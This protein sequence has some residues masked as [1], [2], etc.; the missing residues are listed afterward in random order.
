MNNLFQEARYGFRMLAKNPGFTLVVVLTLALGI[1]ANSALF[2]VV[3][4]VLLKPLPFADAERLV[5][6]WNVNTKESGNGFSVSY[7]DFNDY[8]V[9][10]QSFEQMAAFRTRDLTLTGMGEA[11]RLRGATVTSDLFPLLGVAPQLGRVFTPE[12]DKA[13]NHAAILSDTLWRTRFKADP[14]AV[15]RTVSINSQSYTIV[16][17][18]PPK[19]TFPISSDPAELWIGAAVDNEGGGG[20]LTNQRGNHTIEVIGRLKPGATLAQAQAEMSR[21][22]QALE[23]QYPGENPDT[24]A[25]VV[26]FFERVVGDVKLA[27]LLLLGAVGCVLLIACGNVANLLLA[28]AASRQKE[29]AV[30]AALGANRW[31]VVR[32]LLVESLLLALLGGGAGLLVAWWG[33]DLLLKLVPGGL[34]RVGETTLNA[35]VLGFTLLISVVTGVL[36]GLVP[37][38]HSSRF[39]LVTTLKEGGRG[40]G[41]G[42]RGNRTRNALIVAQVAIAFVLLVCAGLL[43]NSFW[44]LQQVNPGFDP[45]N[46]L[47]F[48]VSLP[49]TKYAQNEQ[50]ESFYQRLTSRVG[51]LPGV[52]SVSATS[53]LP[54]SGQ[55]SGVGFAIEGVP[56][57]PN[58]PFPHESSLRI[59]QPGYFSTMK[60][61]L[62]Q[63]RDFDAR[64]TLMGSQVVIINETLARK[65]FLG[66]NPIGRRINPS[67]GID[68]RG[69]QWREIVGIVKDVHHASLKEAADEESYVPHAQAPVNSITMV[70]RTNNDPHNLI[71]SVGREVSALDGELPIFNVR[72]LEETLSRSLAQQRFNTL[73]L[74]IFA[75]VALLLTAV[76]LYGVLA[77]SVT[78][79]T[80]EFG[81]R[82][83]LGAQAR[84]VLG[85]VLRQGMKLTLIGVGIGLI[86]ALALTR[87]MAGFV[88]G[89]GVTDPMTFAG[90]ALL[91]IVIALF[92]CY[93]PARRA[94]K[95]DPMIALRYE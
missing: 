34:P 50:V 85:L 89:I 71:A 10:Q 17:V 29:V 14:N 62:M 22:A 67:F 83:A 91:L 79:R 72:T 12:E 46:V 55:N 60:I 24:G 37:A 41:D 18:M 2:S 30:R 19:F 42:G 80:H 86:G 59:V 35:R 61:P 8:R 6:V 78:Q 36:F 15:G 4:A 74:V 9:Q 13:G 87:L 69:I 43:A 7:P 38:L 33:T 3:N 77:Y 66:Q 53:V 76:G 1:G 21:I 54:L 58:K 64:D 63:G 16:G 27:L 75:G 11:A 94:T 81:I 95:V 52:T 47:T 39:D 20:A 93:I 56:T 90:I 25:L 57:E 5:T 31:R 26:P 68:Q 23:K 92:A 73:L 40:A 70:A 32:Q 51:A 88:F 65:H 44:H 49:V 45:K 82:L 84:N 48:R 28:R